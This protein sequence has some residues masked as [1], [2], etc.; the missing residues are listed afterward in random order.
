MKFNAL[1]VAAMVITSVNASGK[2]RPR[3]LFKKVGGLT[4]SESAWS[5][6]DKNNPEPGSSQ[7][8]P[9]RGMGQR[10]LQSTLARKLRSG[11]SRNSP[12]HK[13][14]PGPPQDSLAH[15]SRPG[16]SQDP[17]KDEPRPGS[18]QD[19]PKDEPRPGHHRIADR[20]TDHQMSQCIS[21]YDT[22][23]A[24]EP[25]KK[26]PVCDPIV[27]ELQASWEKIS[28]FDSSFSKQIPDFYELLT[29]ER[30][31]KLDKM[32]KKKLIRFKKTNSEVRMSGDELEDMVRMIE[33]EEK[34]SVMAASG[35]EEDEEVTEE[36]EKCARF[37]SWGN[38]RMA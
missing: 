12:K 30:R 8:S 9:R 5:L 35:D 29:K 16:P 1:V 17:P 25:R 13:S 10:L 4:R 18:S 22:P 7:D 6:L 15:G 24:P 14:R 34:N 3:S 2:G 32:M 27:R 28:D 33:F 23:Q 26:D 19:P 37:N 20:I 38:A 21:R 31:E 36:G 11:S